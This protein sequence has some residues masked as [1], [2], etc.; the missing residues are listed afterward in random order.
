VHRT[1][2]LGISNDLPMMITVIDTDEKVRK[3]IT[4]LDDMVEEGL[5]VLSDVDV[6]KYTHSPAIKPESTETG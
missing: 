1:G 2:F 3:A 5:I 6:I 4:A